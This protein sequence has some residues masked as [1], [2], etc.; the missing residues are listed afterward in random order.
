M[1][2]VVVQGLQLVPWG[3]VVAVVAQDLQSV[4]WGLP[5]RHQIFHRL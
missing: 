5:R 1:A 2:V 3:L 4:R